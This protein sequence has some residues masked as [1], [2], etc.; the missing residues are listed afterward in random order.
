MRCFGDFNDDRMCDLCK[1]VNKIYH[2]KCK[3]VCDEKFNLNERLREIKLNCRHR[4]ECWDEYDKFDGCTKDYN[5][6]GRFTP[7]CKPT[8]ECEKY[9]KSK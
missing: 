4:E 5:G 9:C 8:L 2:D 7:E 6:I 1:M 3:E